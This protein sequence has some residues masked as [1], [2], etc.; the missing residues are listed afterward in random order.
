MPKEIAMLSSLSRNWWIA[1]LRGMFA[2]LLG[3]AAFVWPGA[4]LEV[5]ILLFGAYALVDGA[6]TLLLGVQALGTSR[7]L[8]SIIGGL[9]GIVTGVVTFA[10]PGL[11]TLSLVY[12][13]AGWAVMTGVLQ[14]TTA[15]RLRDVISGEWRLAVGGALSIV[16]GLLLMTGPLAGALT[17]VFLFGIYAVAAGISQLAFGLYIRG[18]SQRLPRAHSAASAAH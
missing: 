16:F 1:A 6:T 3:L 14:I 17:L 5:L 15:I 10:M 4:T 11:V 13:V 18:L 2:I 8:P 9:I 12:V 7:A